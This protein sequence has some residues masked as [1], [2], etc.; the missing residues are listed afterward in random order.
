M[1]LPCGLFVSV[2]DVGDEAVP[3]VVVHAGDETRG[4]INNVLPGLLFLGHTVALRRFLFRR[5]EIL[6]VPLRVPNVGPGNEKLIDQYCFDDSVRKCPV[7]QAYALAYFVRV[8]LC[9]RS[10]LG[11]AFRR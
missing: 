11:C 3:L 9:S 10:I 8:G 1:T 4:V 7:A 6:M 2:P 5:N